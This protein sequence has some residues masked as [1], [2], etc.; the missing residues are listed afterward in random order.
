MA[1]TV[2]TKML[3]TG[4]Q[5][6]RQGAAVESVTFRCGPR[7]RKAVRGPI[8][9][10]SLDHCRHRWG[11]WKLPGA[12]QVEVGM[13]TIDPPIPPTAPLANTPAEPGDDGVQRSAAP[14]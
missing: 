13:V 5:V 3:R 2:S 11:P 4:D 6:T 8:F 12:A 14:F 10:L 1:R 9:F 7:L